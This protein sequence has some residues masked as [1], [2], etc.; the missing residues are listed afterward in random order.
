MRKTL[1]LLLIIL[2][3]NAIAYIPPSDFI[4]LETAKRCISGHGKLRGVEQKGDEINFVDLELSGNGLTMGSKVSATT[5]NAKPIV[6]NEKVALYVVQELSNCQGDVAKRIKDYLVAHGIDVSK[7]SLGFF[8]FDP[9]FIIGDVDAQLWIDKQN[10]LPV[11]EKTPNYETVFEHWTS[12]SMLSD[13]KW[14]STL[15]LTAN[16]SKIKLDMA[17][18]VEFPRRK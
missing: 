6:T 16:Q 14:P 3:I 11:K 8:G 7:V 9:V 2:G 17:E 5:S 12:L 4:I 10:F 18:V 13:K 15:S 1:G